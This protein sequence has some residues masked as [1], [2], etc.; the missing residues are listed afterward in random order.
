MTGSDDRVR[1]FGPE[2]FGALLAYWAQAFSGFPNYQPVTSRLL[3]E[4]LFD[5]RNAVEAFD[6]AGLFLAWQGPEVVGLSYGGR[7]SELVCRA[8]YHGWSGGAE[9]YLGI[10]HV[11]PSA[12]HAGLGAQLFQSARAH[13]ADTRRF[14]VD[15]ECL[16]PFFGNSEGPE[17]PLF[18]MTEG[19]GVPAADAATEG[20]LSRRGFPPRERA[21]T[22][23]LDHEG[24][25]LIAEVALGEVAWQVTE[26]RV[27]EVGGPPDGWVP[28]REESRFVAVQGVERGRVLVAAIGFPLTAGNLWGIYELR[29]AQDAQG[30]GLGSSATR[31][32][33]LEHQ[34]RGARLTQV[35]T[36]PTLSPAAHR[37]YLRLG[38]REVRAWNIF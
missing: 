33:L 19:I 23:E 30:R 6:P 34:R 27:A 14:M 29:A 5:R 18:G 7:R 12:R 17:P 36:I 21:L 9:G 16:N 1:P 15:G 25:T 3:R 37:L 28:Y 11:L 20:F 10:L 26:D 31:R 32:L 35:V 13:V 38:F 2:H 22:L 4:R 8:L 24:R